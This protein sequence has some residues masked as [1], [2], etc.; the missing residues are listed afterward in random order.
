MT[1]NDAAELIT[2][3]ATKHRLAL[4]SLSFSGWLFPSTSF[5]VRGD[6][7]PVERFEEDFRYELTRRMENRRQ[8]W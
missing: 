5:C 1:K 3:L 7:I 4:T 6:F 2:R 8:M